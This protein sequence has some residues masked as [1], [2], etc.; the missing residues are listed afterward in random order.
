MHPGSGRMPFNPA[1]PFVV[2]RR[3][4]FEGKVFEGGNDFPPSDVSVRRLHQMYDLRKIDMK[5]RKDEMKQIKERLFPLNWK[6]LP[7]RELFKLIHDAF[8]VKPKNRSHAFKLVVDN[9]AA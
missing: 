8:G 7:N 9:G 5:T 2:R 3:V 6:V 1:G 4:L